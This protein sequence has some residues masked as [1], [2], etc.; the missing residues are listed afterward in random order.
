ML[1][2]RNSASAQNTPV[3]PTGKMLRNAT[4]TVICSRIV[5]VVCTESN[6]ICDSSALTS[7]A[8]EAKSAWFI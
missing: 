4:G 8:C 6:R 1:S 7:A 5:W 2:I 3:T